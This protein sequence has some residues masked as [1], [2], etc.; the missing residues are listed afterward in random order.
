MQKEK[1]LKIYPREFP[2]Y[3]A[4]VNY[5]IERGIKYDEIKTDFNYCGFLITVENDWN[6]F[7]FRI[8]SIV[9][10]SNCSAV[11]YQHLWDSF[12]ND[13]IQLSQDDYDEV[14]AVS[15]TQRDFNVIDRLLY[16]PDPTQNFEPVKLKKT[17][18]PTL[19]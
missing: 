5:L 10:E 3:Q 19:H 18:K 16:Q 13:L 2:L 9:L 12:C 7:Y 17:V 14:L 1:I 6:N 11:E 15:I 8:P 4:S